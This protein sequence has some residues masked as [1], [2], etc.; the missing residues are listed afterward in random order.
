MCDF[1]K[2]TAFSRM[3]AETGLPVG[4]TFSSSLSNSWFAFLATWFLLIIFGFPIS[5]VMPCVLR[6][7][8][9]TSLSKLGAQSTLTVD[10]LNFSGKQQRIK[11][12]SYSGTVSLFIKVALVN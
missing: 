3:T 7:L 6:E 8:S 2:H 4:S 11:A 1:S 5:R 12:S 9:F 10:L